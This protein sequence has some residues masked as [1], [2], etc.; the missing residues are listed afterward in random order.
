MN[1]NFLRIA[2]ANI[3]TK[4]LNIKENKNEI[5]KY[6]NYAGNNYIDLLIFPELSLTGV[7]AGEFITSNEIINQCEIALKEILE[8][9]KNYD[10]IFLLGMPI[11]TSTGI[12]SVMFLIHNGEIK[13]IYQK[14]NFNELENLYLKDGE[15]V[16]YYFDNKEYSI[17]KE[18]TVLN[19]NNCGLQVVFENDLLLNRVNIL[20]ETS[21]LLVIGNLIS[22]IDNLDDTKEI[23]QAL[24]KQHNIAI[25]YSAPS[26]T[27]SSS[28]GIYSSNKYIIENG[29]ILE[30]GRTFNFGLIFSE[31]NIDEILRGNREYNYNLNDYIN[32]KE[33][34]YPLRRKLSKTPYFNYEENYSNKMQ[35]ILEIQSQ[36]LA[37]RLTQISDKKIFL[38]L[39]GGLDSTLALIVASL[40]Y[41]KLGLDSK[42]IYAITMPGLGTTTRTKTN[43]ENLAKS[44]NVTLKSIDIKDSVLQHF[45]DIEHD[46]NDFD[47][48]FENAQARERTQILMD[49]ANK[50]GGIVLGTGNMSEIALGWS[51][52]NGDH[53]SMY[54]VNAGLPKTLLKLVV[55]Y[56]AN[57]T[58]N[59]LLKSILLDILDTPI[60]PELL[61]SDN[62]GKIIQKTENN[63]GPYELHDFFIYHLLRNKSSIDNIK[64][65]TKLAFGEKYTEEEINKWLNKFLWRFSSQ[66]FKRNVA[67][68]CPKI[69]D[70]SLNSKIGFIM[71]SDIDSNWF[72]N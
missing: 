20:S 37:R 31:I 36:S 3:K 46:P 28:F 29:N 9:T 22:D 21:I 25:A 43:A 35:N 6:L 1:R 40:A 19:I 42:N 62:N 69:L 12:H 15:N 72:N 67:P 24:S 26:S 17:I 32:L 39:S 65:M 47:I 14:T 4:L 68:D 61:P 7:S 64:W 71:P 51:T 33:F 13:Q 11:K 34:N 44:Y 27:E 8:K 57:S 41:F 55:Q 53:M 16:N 66:Q 60:S 58:T 54:S 48:T 45:K 50:H 5:L 56:I 38:G 2:S 18:P 59:E 49:L 23:L 10:T 30:K 70:Y 52:Y 63:V